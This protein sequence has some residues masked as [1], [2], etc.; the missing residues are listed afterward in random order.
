MRGDPDGVPGRGFEPPDGVHLLP[1]ADVVGHELH[2]WL[3]DAPVLDDVVEDGA[4]AV[5][6]GVQADG[7][8]RLVHHQEVVG[9]GDVG[10][11]KEG[12]KFNCV[13]EL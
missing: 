7:H 11:C 12:W 10:D 13:Q 6:E 8:H 2:L 1:G 9:V 4:A 5:A 3:H